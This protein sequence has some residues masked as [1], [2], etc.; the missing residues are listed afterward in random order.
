MGACYENRS[1]IKVK[2]ENNAKSNLIESVK[3]KYI[4]QNIFSFLDENIKLNLIIY[5]KEYQK[6]FGIDI[7]YYK[8]K[9]GK[10]KKGEK[11]GTEKNLFLLTLLLRI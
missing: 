6:L 7:D 4:I 5:N 1:L 8:R 11:N 3:S 9:S 10:Y 2:A